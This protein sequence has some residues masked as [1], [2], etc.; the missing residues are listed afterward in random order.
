LIKTTLLRGALLLAL[1]LPAAPA[2]ADQSTVCLPTS[3]T[4][5][6][7]TIVTGANAAMK[8]LLTNSAGSSEPANDCSEAPVEGQ[9][10]VDTSGASPVKK[11]FD[12]SEWQVQG[13]LDVSTNTWTPPIGGGA[14]SLA[15]GATTDLWSVPQSYV[16]ITGTTTITKLAGSSAVIGTLKTVNFAG[17]LTL[18]H[19]ATQLILPGGRSLTTAVGDK[20]LVVALGGDNVAI[21]DYTPATGT[22]INFAPTGTIVSGL[23][24]TCPVS[25]IAGNGGTIGS[26]A[27]GATTRAN[28]DTAELYAVLWALDATAAP[29]YTS[30][31]SASTRGASAAADFAANKRLGMPDLRGTF[32]RGVDDSRGI[33]AARL[34]GSQQSGATSVSGVSASASSSASSSFSGNALPPHVHSQTHT[35]PG[36]AGFGSFPSAS[37]ATSPGGNINTDAASAGTPSGSVSTSV[38]TT[39]SLSGATE[40][41][42]IN[43]AVKQCVKL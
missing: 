28:A 33:D 42:P 10:W 37:S 14:T 20:A 17:A 4:V 39:V 40:T 36:F 7:L 1:L 32:L 11:I 43:T 30:A 29:I 18:T 19:D 27:S 22:A 21:V 5:S 24:A 38:T 41:R 34:L 35:D 25:T 6:G 15:S 31:G 3:G 26:A 2:I 16:V 8:A 23:F 9:D 12:G 13:T